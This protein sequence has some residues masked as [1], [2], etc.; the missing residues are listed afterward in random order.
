MLEMLPDYYEYSQ[1]MQAILEAE[2]TEYD[3]LRADITDVLAQFSVPTATWGLKIW[4]NATGLPI[5][6]AL[7]NET[8]RARV[9]GRL[10]GQGIATKEKIK[11]VV[12]TF[13]TMATVTELFQVIDRTDLTVAEVKKYTVAQLALMDVNNIHDSV[14][15]NKLR[16]TINDPVGV[17]ANLADIQ[18]AIEDAKPAHI[19]YEI[20][21]TV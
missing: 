6:E 2:G 7:S 8:R 12:E 15:G 10:K 13:V 16:V 4:E 1:V 21:T 18:R 5:N 9:L 17:P 19:Q 20:I 3:D 14:N 11:Q